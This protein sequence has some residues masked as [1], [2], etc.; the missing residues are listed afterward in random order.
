[1]YKR[2]LFLLC[3]S[4]ISVSFLKGGD[5][6]DFHSVK[7]GKIGWS[8][9]ETI[10]K[11]PIVS[12]Y[13]K[14]C[15]PPPGYGEV[16]FYW[17]TG[18]KLTKE[19]LRWQLDFLCGK[20][21]PG[22]SPEQLPT[23][24]PLPRIQ[25]IQVNAAH[26]KG[27][28]DGKSYGLFGNSYPL[29]PPLFTPEFWNLWA[30]LVEESDQR[31]IGV[32]ISDYTLAWP[33]QGF[34]V[35]EVLADPARQGKKLLMKK[36]RLTKKTA[37]NS[38]DSVQNEIITIDVPQPD[39]SESIDRYVF[40]WKTQPKSIDP[41]DEKT[42]TL[43][44][45]RFFGESERHVPEQFRRS[46][47]YYFQDE[48]LLGIDGLIWT[49]RFAEEF[50]KRKGYDIRPKL[51]HLFEQ[52]DDTTPKI[53]LD[54][55]DVKI[56][57][58]E[59]GYFKPVGTWH[60]ERG[61][62]YG[63][64]QMGRGQNPMEYGDYFRTIR[65]Y[66]APG[67]DTPGSGADIIKGKVSS[68]ISHL[69][70]A[71]R[72]W[73]EGYHSAGWGMTLENL[74][75]TTN[76]NYAVGCNLLC[77]HGLY[78]TTYG[79][80][81]EWAPP[82]YHFRMPYWRH[83]GI[84][85][86]YFERLS[87]LLSQGNHVADVAIV[88]PAEQGA[89]G[90]DCNHSTKIAFD[91]GRKIYRNGIDFDFIDG[92]SIARSA[93][94]EKTLNVAGES[95]RV[96]ILPAMKALRWDA[97]EKI[98]E[99]HRQGGIVIALECLLEASDRI[100]AN[101]P[102]LQEIMHEI[103]IDGKGILLASENKTNHRFVGEPR[104]YDGG[105]KG[106]WVWSEKPSQNAAFKAIWNYGKCRAKIRFHADNE[107]TLFVNG[108]QIASASDYEKGWN[109]EMNLNNGDV[110]VA[111]CHD[112]DQPGKRTAGFFFA[113]VVDG[114]TVLNS[115]TF[116]C[117]TKNEVFNNDRWRRSASLEILET[118]NQLF[119]HE[120]HITGVRGQLL[121][122]SA[123]FSVSVDKIISENLVRD[124]EVSGGAWVLH[125]RIPT[126]EGNVEVYFVQH[127]AKDSQAVFRAS[128]DVQLWNAWTGQA[129]KLT[130]TKTLENGRTQVRLPLDVQ[131]GR[132][133]AFLPKGKSDTT[134][135]VYKRYVNEGTPRVIDGDWDF[136]L[137]PTLDNAFGDFR[138]PVKKNPFD[139]SSMLG[140]EARR[141]KVFQK[142]AD[143]SG[144]DFIDPH[145][146]DS[147][148]PSATFGYGNQMFLYNL[149]NGETDQEQ[150]LESE[151]LSG[152]HPIVIGK[153]SRQLYRFSWRW[154]VEGEPGDQ[155]GYHGL[156]KIVSDYF[157]IVPE[158][159]N[160][161]AASLFV[162]KNT[163]VFWEQADG[164]MPGTIKPSAIWIDG[165][166]MEQET[167][168]TN[169][170][171]H[172]VIKFVKPGRSYVVFSTSR[173][174]DTADPTPLA[175]KWFDRKTILRYQPFAAKND[176]QWFRFTAP[177]GLTE[178]ALNPVG[179]GT[180]FVHGKEVQSF[181]NPDGQLIRITIPQ[182]L[183]RRDSAT[184]T[185]RMT[186]IPWGFNDGG[187]FSEPVFLRCEKGTSPLGDWSK[188][189]VLE[190]YSGGV[191]YRK[192]VH[193]DENEL[194]ELKSKNGRYI[195]ELGQ[196]IASCEVRVNGVLAAVL[197]SSPWQCDIT[198]LVVPND[199]VIEILVMSTL[200][201]HYQTIPSHYRGNPKAGLIGPV[202]LL[203]ETEIF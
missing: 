24:Y 138:L 86:R 128:G 171:H 188:Q 100:G 120:Y 192:T 194:K 22:V 153:T 162:E 72:V 78:Y 44:A 150:K 151:L 126:A 61:L 47:N 130:E 196:V 68:S 32:G 137:V 48:L 65:W 111:E 4:V 52:I 83:A 197:T 179:H 121:Q 159:V 17:F 129:S 14:F 90:F 176:E 154:G 19:R 123:D 58:S 106:R 62:L 180:V 89:A 15:V 45:D 108:Q 57:L 51:P 16:P 199:N 99:F 122:N 95:Y 125:R 173:E 142:N 56:A 29:D 41:M 167:E 109:G 131:E 166:K 81:W 200:S 112:N 201:N 117:S 88:Y 127:A 66:S 67:H 202:R 1:M 46:L 170:I 20:T 85:L 124:F 158:G 174:S 64:D 39:D 163:P 178:M 164:S 21:L 40:Y 183:R 143:F 157:L 144:K 35:D 101:D 6:P 18:D 139:Q 195:L 98:R 9:P 92:Q 10:R 5:I 74:T 191:R 12:L 107:G 147:A 42:G 77:L 185:I 69:Y 71:P 155:H 140:A 104:S 132:I 25:G 31:G 136:E 53:R 87:F 160:Y 82:C 198:K 23:D 168:L 73:L 119:V 54:Y 63:C 70:G 149:K 182:H 156:K 133:I 50:Q 165:Q 203:K 145:F 11:E 181:N 80:F 184:A 28:I 193:F 134:I 2:F 175:M 75:R 186:D 27:S 94:G 93:I 96:L 13:E 103:F 3:F 102:K 60:S 113:A 7:Q 110:I 38:D 43:I 26:A 189:G 116:L 84:W 36:T 135:P 79:G 91:L 76:E 177:P 105:F 37:T 172:V 148:C 152:N 118:V 169:G 114:Q 30:W 8:D 115:E 187:V 161:F 34:V 141:F 190:T 59:E 55:H 97:V 146:D 49:P 33:G